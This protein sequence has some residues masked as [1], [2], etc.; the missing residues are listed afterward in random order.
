MDVNGPDKLTIEK[1][2]WHGSS[3]HLSFTDVSRLLKIYRQDVLNAYLA[4]PGRSEAVIMNNH[5]R[6]GIL[7]AQQ[8]IK[9]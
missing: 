1:S 4:E 2:G 3:N 6:K 5:E 7:M 9:H 8:F